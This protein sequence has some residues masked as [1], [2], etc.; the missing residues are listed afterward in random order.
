M[1]FVGTAPWNTYTLWRHQPW[2]E[3]DLEPFWCPLVHVVWCQAQ[4]RAVLESV[5]SLYKNSED[6][7]PWKTSAYHHQAVCIL[8]V[9][10]DSPSHS[11]KEISFFSSC[12]LPSLNKAPNFQ[13]LLFH[14]S[15]HRL[16]RKQITNLNSFQT[17]SQY[18][19][20]DDIREIKGKNIELKI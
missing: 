19:F 7:S 1:L 10:K 15:N 4:Y 3:T 18:W 6:F 9:G 8:T 20:I 11:V 2:W 14:S 5:F 16:S 13:V 12:S 17:V